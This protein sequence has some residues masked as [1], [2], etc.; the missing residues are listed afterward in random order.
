MRLRLLRILARLWMPF[1]VWRR[2]R[3]VAGRVVVI[4]VDTPGA[5][6][7]AATL[8]TTN[9][10]H[11]YLSLH[12][13]YLGELQRERRYGRMLRRVV[14]R[15]LLRRMD[16]II[17][18]DR[19]RRDELLAENGLAEESTQVFVLP[20]SYRGRA[21]PTSSTFYHDR[22]GLPHDE[23]LVLLAG[24]INAW[25]HFD[26]LAECAGRQQR[27]P[28]Y[29]LVVQ[30][31]T[32]LSAEQRRS[33][34]AVA[35]HRV[36]VSSEPVPEDELTD[37]FASATVGAALYTG[38]FHQNQS[39]VGGSSGKMMAYLRC[40]LPVIMVDSPGV[41][42]VIETF[43]C[44]RLIHRLDGDEFNEA[45]HDVVVNRDR[46]SANAVRCYNE[47]YEFDRNFT[48]IHRFVMAVT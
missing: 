31:R 32:A 36:V 14:E 47:L 5:L 28:F 13:Q 2:V 4:A 38:D 16:A 7:S 33:V 10:V 17:T 23:P 43:Q 22:F 26:F 42:E 3:A 40:G 19:Y 48:A 35:G 18:Q 27:R 9:S 34:E 12:I 21:T 20:N 41:T 6:A 29:T 37:A 44:G 45:V 15:L 11:L 39:F 1:F 8:L 24:A 30:S 46:Y 25:S